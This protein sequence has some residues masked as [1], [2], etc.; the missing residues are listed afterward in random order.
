MLSSEGT[1][2]FIA[3]AGI[4]HNGD[5]STAKSLM[6]MAKIAGAD[7]VK[8]QKR[9]PDV[10]VPTKQKTEIRDTPWGQMTYLDYKKKIEFDFTGY[11]ELDEYSQEIGIPWSA[12]AWDFG[13][14]EFLEK[15]DLPYHKV[16]SALNTHLD[17]VRAVADTGKPVVISTGMA[18][19][20]QIEAFVGVLRD[21]NTD[22]TV[23][24]TVST[25]PAKEED[26]NLLFIKTLK[27]RLGVNVGYSGHEASVSPSLIA[28]SLGAQVI[29]R[30]V[31]LDRSMWGTDHAASLEP[32]GLT[33]LISMI[34]KVPI[35]LGNGVKK[36]I[37]GE[38]AMAAKMRY[39]EV[40]S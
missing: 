33:R 26:L 31:T 30:H 23:L 9:D 29:E 39:W 10:C 7:S 12:S 34:R 11:S 8:F 2:H 18:S 14:L 37:E 24:H 22:F 5:L 35:V 6:L 28:A 4:N 27:D 16:A 21:R 17:F 20:S 13:S 36:D 32:E 3:E 25:Y 1:V 40:S 38:K 19:W 15:F